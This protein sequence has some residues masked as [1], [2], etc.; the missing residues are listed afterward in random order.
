MPS[1]AVPVRFRTVV[2]LVALAT[3]AATSGCS[4]GGSPPVPSPGGA[5]GSTGGGEEGGHATGGAFGGSPQG[6]APG[7]G[8]TPAAGGTGAV[9]AGGAGG[10]ISSS[11]GGATGA[12]GSPN[13]PGGGN[14]GISAAGGTTAPGGSTG[15]GQAG[16][17]VGG[18]STS[19][20]G[21]NSDAGGGG[22]T[23]ATGGASGTGGAS[24]DPTTGRWQRV[25]SCDIVAP[26]NVFHSCVDYFATANSAISVSQREMAACSD[27]GGTPLVEVPC[28]GASSLGSCISTIDASVTSGDAEYTQAFGYPGLGV[29]AVILASGCASDGLPYLPP[30]A[31]PS[32][33]APQLTC[34]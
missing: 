22:G 12:G 30:T 8:G 7:T 21:G 6:G 28:A 16:S 9:A 18:S 24:C 31:D 13:S 23:G 20:T 11:S 5:S 1:L 27:E 14:G 10:T 17:G 19:A 29:T 25:L 33:G 32:A 4:S 3:N 2:F 34:P 26:G 15:T